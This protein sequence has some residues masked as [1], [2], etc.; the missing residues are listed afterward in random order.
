MNASGAG[1]QPTNKFKTAKMTFRVPSGDF[2]SRLERGRSYK[3]L[4]Q[5]RA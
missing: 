5:K 3:D 4:L 2:L 1:G